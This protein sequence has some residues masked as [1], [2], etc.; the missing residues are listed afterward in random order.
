[1][2]RD[3]LLRSLAVLTIGAL[4]AAACGGDDGD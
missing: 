2:V 1:M 3:R 4:G